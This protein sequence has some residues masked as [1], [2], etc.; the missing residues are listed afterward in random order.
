MK[1]LITGG[2]GFIGS[3]IA[4]A[5]LKKGY[6]IAVIDNLTTGTRDNVHKNAVF[7]KADI[8]DM[9]EISRI[10][11]KEKPHIVNHHAA[12][13]SVTES[14][15]NPA[16]TLEVNVVG[17]ANLLSAGIMHNLQKFIFSSTGGAIYG[18]TKITPTP[19]TVEPQPPSP[20]GLSKLFA[21]HVIRYYGKKHQLPYVILR[22]AN[23]YG[24]RQNPH[25]E[26]G[27]VAI[28][29]EKMKKN[30]QPTIFGDGSKTR[31]YVYVEDIVNANVRAIDG[32]DSFLANLG[33]GEEIKDQTVF[34][35]IARA[36]DYK[37]S[38]QY[39]P[40]RAGEML[41]S[42]LDSSLAYKQLGWQSTISFE[43]GI[44]KTIASY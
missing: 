12:L 37:Q 13:A 6:Q 23:V 35:I 41:K 8:R 44:K 42:V 10:F 17:T 40:V 30:E 24:P 31:D 20:Y 3:H 26:A 38:P 9:K 33:C 5:Y 27:V 14:V 25:G 19:E 29:I 21:E 7:Y 11:Q 1:I 28:F 18:D 32:N 36:L 4:D 22:Y 15:S 34:D 43:D 2:A 16:E 39:A